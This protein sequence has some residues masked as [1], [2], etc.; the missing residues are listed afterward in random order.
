MKTMWKR[1]YWS[2]YKIFKTYASISL[3]LNAGETTMRCILKVDIADINQPR[4]SEK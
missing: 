4:I 2:N 3:L 1:F